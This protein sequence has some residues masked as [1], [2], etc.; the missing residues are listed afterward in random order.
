MLVLSRKVGEEIVLPI[1]GVTIGVVAVAGKRV[2]LGITA[3]PDI[4]VHR[5]EVWQRARASRSEVGPDGSD[6]DVMPL[7][8]DEKWQPD[9]GSPFDRE[10]QGEPPW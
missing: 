9:A 2:R 6:A 4:K 8:H 7:P 3:P 10:S 5:K 1:H